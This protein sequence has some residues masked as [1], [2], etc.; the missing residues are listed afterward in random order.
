MTMCGVA[1][2]RSVKVE[3]RV[4]DEHV[5]RVHRPVS[6]R[7]ARTSY[8]VEAEAI[9]CPAAPI[10]PLRSEH[11]RCPATATECP[12]ED[13]PRI[14]P[15]VASLPECGEAPAPLASIDEECVVPVGHRVGV[16][17]VGIEVDFR[18]VTYWSPRA[19]HSWPRFSSWKR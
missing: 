8:G 7:P 6:R 1:A 18:S 3:P 10:P 4:S 2:D 17:D 14:S 9:S 12:Y 11:A 13:L 5:H 16:A 15:F 19:G